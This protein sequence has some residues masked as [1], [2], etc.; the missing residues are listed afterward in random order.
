LG[1][2]LGKTTLERALR[3]AAKP[4]L[5]AAKRNAPND[6]G[7]LEKSLMIGKR[8]KRGEAGRVAYAA[9]MK[10]TG[11]NKSSAVSAMREARRGAGTSFVQFYLGPRLGKGGGGHAHL[12]EFGVGPR[13]TKDGKLTGEV[14]ADPFLRPA[15]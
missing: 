8:L 6:D 2:R 4:M 12:V 15:F 1:K 3:Q 7:D 11:G 10:A 13:F 9:M 14:P 5:E